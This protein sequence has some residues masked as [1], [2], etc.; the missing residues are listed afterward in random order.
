MDNCDSLELEMMVRVLSRC[1]QAQ[2][3]IEITELKGTFK[4]KFVILPHSK[5]RCV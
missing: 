2:L 5:N 1:S 4:L 3:N